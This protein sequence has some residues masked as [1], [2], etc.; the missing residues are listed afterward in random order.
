MTEAEI[1]VLRAIE[2]RIDTVAWV[3]RLIGDRTFA[4][5]DLENTQGLR[6]ALADCQHELRVVQRLTP[7]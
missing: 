6:E 5:D 1:E 7:N 4:A 2:R 3:V